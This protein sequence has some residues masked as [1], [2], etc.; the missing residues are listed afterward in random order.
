MTYFC[1]AEIWP[2]EWY[3]GMFI[4]ATRSPVLTPAENLRNEL[5]GVPIASDAISPAELQQLRNGIG[6][7][8][9]HP[10]DIV[11]LV[12]KMEFAWCVYLL[13]VYRL[14]TWRV[15]YSLNGT[16]APHEMF[17]YLESK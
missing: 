11:P 8:L 14:E 10:A 3:A 1:V 12:N 9:S 2:H 7:L 4:I 6:A 17:A 13:A 5:F 16:T 15:T